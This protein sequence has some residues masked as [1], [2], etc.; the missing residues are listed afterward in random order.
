MSQFIKKIA[1]TFQLGYSEGMQYSF[2]RGC[3][4]PLGA[5]KTDEGINFAFHSSIEEG[6][7]LLLYSTNS[8]TP[9]AQM[10]L[11]PKIHR[12]GSIWHVRVQNLPHIF[13]YGI[14][15]GSR[16]LIDP[17]A[18]EVNS[19]PDWGGHFYAENQPLAKFSA[20]QS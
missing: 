7:S 2:E 17:Y 4:N 10:I 18:K 6:V 16:I 15:V 19:T 9:F 3:P 1:N 11:D 5:S 8:K 14:K 13:E 12:T 20:P